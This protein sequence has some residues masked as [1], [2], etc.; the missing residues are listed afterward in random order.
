LKVTPVALIVLPGEWARARGI[1]VIEFP[2]DWEKEGRHA[3]LIRN[4]R[5]LHEGKP[6][7]VIAFP[8]GKGTWHTC[9]HAEKAGIPVV[10]VSWGSTEVAAI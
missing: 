4:E 2:A 5:M 8:G 10:K 9:F 6:N 1:K 3:A 7:L